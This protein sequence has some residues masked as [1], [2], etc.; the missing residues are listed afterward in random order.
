MG[1][2]TIGEIERKSGR[3]PTIFSRHT[4]IIPQDRLLEQTF[5]VIGAGSLG[6]H[7]VHVLA[8]MGAENIRVF[9]DDTVELHNMS[10]QL[11]DR[12]SLGQPKVDALKRVIRHMHGVEIEA[13]KEKYEPGKDIFGIVISAVDN[14]DVRRSIWESINGA[15]NV[16]LYIESR[17]GGRFASVFTLEPTDV[18]HAEAYAKDWLFPQEEGL[19]G[20]CTEKMTTFIPWIVAGHIGALVTAHLKNEVLPYITHF[21]MSAFQYPSLLKIP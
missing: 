13:I 9:D 20:K 2:Q 4:D 17:A 21:D 1:T 19:Q 18:K 11:Y 10:V 8:M 15:L 7:I 16:P 14:M 3:D 6:S 5:T 12:K